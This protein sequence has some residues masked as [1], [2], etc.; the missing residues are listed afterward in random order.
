MGG[1]GGEPW[2]FSNLHFSNSFLLCSPK[3]QHAEWNKHLTFC[4]MWVAWARQTQGKLL[5]ASWQLK[6]RVQ[7][8]SPPFCSPQTE[9]LGRAGGR[10][11]EASHGRASRLASQGHVLAASHQLLGA[12]LWTPLSQECSLWG[13]LS[14]V[15]R[16]GPGGPGTRQ[17]GRGWPQK[18]KAVAPRRGRG[19]FWHVLST[20]L[21]CIVTMCV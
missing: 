18:H 7:V 16:R 13:V 3:R 21:S 5:V 2:G 19:K 10:V 6:A 17:P 20:V 11:E 4:K 9:T 15:S 1:V 12:P 8:T 14:G